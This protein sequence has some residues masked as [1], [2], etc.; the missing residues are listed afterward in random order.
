[1]QDLSGEWAIE[2][3]HWAGL[4]TSAVIAVRVKQ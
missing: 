1:V 2:N 4:G 3:G